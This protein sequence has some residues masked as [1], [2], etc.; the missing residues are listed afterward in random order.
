M[1]D[2]HDT[3]PDPGQRAAAN[4]ALHTD[5]IETGWWDQHGRPAPWPD[6][7]DPYRPETGHTDR[8]PEITIGKGA[9]GGKPTVRPAW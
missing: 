4:A 9:A 3:F 2:P 6:D 8:L 1:T 7:I 5:N